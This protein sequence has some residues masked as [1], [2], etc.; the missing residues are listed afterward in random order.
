MTKSELL[1][2][3]IRL[4]IVQE[5]LGRGELTT[6]ELRRHLPE[7]PTATLY[8]QVNAL[9][10]G[11]VLEVVEERKVRGAVERTLVLRAAAA[12]VDADDAARM[13]VE[14]HR[15]SFLVFVAGLL[16]DFDRYL[17]GAD[18]ADS[19]GA[20]GSDG[21]SSETQEAPDLAGDL[22][23]Y[24]KVA[25]YL[26]DEEMQE[27]IAELRGVIAPRLDNRPHA[28]RRRRLLTTV[29]MP[30]ERRSDSPSGGLSPTGL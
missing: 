22:V 11:Q 30:E 15:R 12:T 27:L 21:A 3:P 6:T 19:P 7:V 9:L 18:N 24:R 16:G 14:E 28:D 1:L 10:D 20:D 2:H 26:S 25:A 17:G 29:L 8:R 4:R 13:S 5:F 23:G